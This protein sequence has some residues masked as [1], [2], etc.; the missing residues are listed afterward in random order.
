MTRTPPTGQSFFARGI[1]QIPR[2]LAVVASTSLV[3]GFGLLG[4]ATPATATSGT[5]AG[6][7]AN[8]TITATNV[9]AADNEAI[10][11]ALNLS[12]PLICLNGVFVIAST[13]QVPS[14]GDA[15]VHLYGIGSTSL[16]GDQSL[17]ERIINV[18]FD[19][20]ALTV[21][22]LTFADGP[23]GAILGY[24]VT[25]A[26]STFMENIG[27]AV[28]G[29]VITVTDSTFM[30]NS[31]GAVYGTD[32]TVTNSDFLRNTLAI[33]GGAVYS[34]GDLTVSESVFVD[35]SASGGG[36]IAGYALI[37]DN[38]TFALNEATGE[39]D[40]GGAI[41]ATTVGVTNSTFIE[42]SAAHE[43]GGIIATAGYVRFSTFINNSAATPL[44]GEDIP[45]AAIYKSRDQILNL[46]ANIFASDDPSLPQLG[47]GAPI[48]AT[49][50][51]DL[52]GNVFSTSVEED[53]MVAASTLFNNSVTSLFGTDWEVATEVP[54]SRGTYSVPLVAGSPALG[55]VPAGIE[56]LE[57]VTTDQRGAARSFP[58]DA[59]AYEL[60]TPATPEQ[61]ATT[62][63]PQT[64]AFALG[65][66]LVLAAGA[67][68]VTLHARMRRRA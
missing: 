10:Q 66:A 30:D 19:D 63:N 41:N 47:I 31:N 34:T 57:E 23:G 49:E 4:G 44:D 17:S 2:P 55:A 42:N 52:G 25:I 22:N 59:G 37:V 20:T 35:N 48:V 65:T 56:G 68:L 54:N 64:G 43:G 36:A 28:N 26:D 67:A 7:T 39:S 29:T 38:S 11:D 3:L 13:L 62:G 27:G 32:I 5:E 60:E 18:L 21:E 9:P 33:Q 51:S 6:C 46:G 12:L 8:N 16:V 53:L 15:S 45:G 61:L 24:N 50:F 40:G 1:S 58:A 14:S